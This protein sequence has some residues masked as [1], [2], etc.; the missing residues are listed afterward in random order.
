MKVIGILG[1]IGAGKNTVAQHL[2]TL[3]CIQD[4]FATP[5]KDAVAAIFGW[6]R[7]LLEGTTEES[8]HF[9][10]TPDLYWSRKLDIHNF[11]PRLAMQYL[12][13]DVLRKHFNEEIWVS[14]L[15]HRLFAAQTQKNIV[16]S[17][18]RFRNELNMIVRNGGK[19]IWVRRGDL[20]EWYE[21]ALLA[22]QNDPIGKRMM[23]TQY[24][25]IHRSEWD[26]AGYPVDYEIHND[27]SLES[28]QAEIES[29][30]RE[31]ITK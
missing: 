15:E 2:C 17:D 19:L 28:L 26:W 3:G 4:S 8:R 1:H 18:A 31:I 29:V 20:P 7:H 21:T 6:D 14:S 24:K 25:N 27:G 11:T 22:T 13:T 9:R 12:G 30:Y 5:L 10:E 23:E 16:I